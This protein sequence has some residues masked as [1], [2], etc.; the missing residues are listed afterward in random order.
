MAPVTRFDRIALAICIVIVL[1]IAG[2]TQPKLTAMAVG[3]IL[4]TL[5]GH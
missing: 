4:D 5:F 2:I 3:K 1:F